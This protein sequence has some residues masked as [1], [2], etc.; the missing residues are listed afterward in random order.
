MN[1]GK[2]ICLMALSL[3]ILMLPA[4]QKKD[5]LEDSSSSSIVSED[6]MEEA[7]DGL[8]H[9]G[10][11]QYA[12]HPS[13]DALRETF[14]ARLEE[15]GYDSNRIA[16][17]Y[18]NANGDQAAAKTICQ[19]FITAQVDLIVAIAA[20]AAAEAAECVAGTDIK[21][22]FAAV[23]DPAGQL[24]MTDLNAPQGNITGVSTSAS[25]IAAAALA[26]QA[27]PGISTMGI[28][29]N[30]EDAEAT[31]K[32]ESVKSYYEE[33]GLTVVTQ[34]VTAADSP[35]AQMTALCDQADAVFIPFDYL[36]TSAMAEV[37]QASTN[38]ATPIYSC[39]Q[40]WVENGALASVG[41]DYGKAGL[42]TADMAVAL[43]E[44][45]AISALPVVTL[46][47]DQTYINHSTL[48]VMHITFPEELMR[49]AIF[50]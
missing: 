15:W 16:V 39:E 8:F 45:R 5:D 17:D 11:I 21:V 30:S 48:E 25:H 49:K 24:G 34:T 27:S 46:N 32:M 50:T 44:G 2:K 7:A 4:C 9:I 31:A 3:L 36:I 42:K 35:S 47:A 6:P 20:P 38:S 13:Y 22:V 28:L 1:L 29:Y 14:L 40:T 19:E 12:E 10:L 43:L 33:Q 26:M 23:E 41:P 18:Q 37:V